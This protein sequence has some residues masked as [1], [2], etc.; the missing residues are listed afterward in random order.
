MSALVELRQMVK[1]HVAN[2][3]YSPLMLRFASTEDLFTASLT[4][5]IYNNEDKMNGFLYSDGDFR[6]SDKFHR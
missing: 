3:F 1:N 4:E 2:T 6:L 5:F